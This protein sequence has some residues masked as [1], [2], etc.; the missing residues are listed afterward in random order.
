MKE[1][2]INIPVTMKQ[3]DELTE[4]E[5]ALLVEAK[6]ATFRSYAPYSNFSV[7]A[8]ALLE[9]GTIVSGSNQENSAYPSGICAERTTIF[10]ANSKY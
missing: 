9:D 6:A 2:N 1:L 3:E 8:A 10:Y 5:K 4:Q 7:G